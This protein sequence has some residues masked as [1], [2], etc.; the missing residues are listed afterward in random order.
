MEDSDPAPEKP[1]GERGRRAAGPS[2]ARA[3]ARRAARLRKCAVIRVEGVERLVDRPYPR[4]V[5]VAYFD[6]RLTA[7]LPILREAEWSAWSASGAAGRP[8][9][10][11]SPNAV[12]LDPRAAV[13]EL[14]S[15]LSGV[16][17]YAESHM[18]VAKWLRTLFEAAGETLEIP[19]RDVRELA[20]DFASEDR[21][22]RSAAAY[23]E[24][25]YA[26]SG[27]AARQATCM[28]A[29]LR[30]L[31]SEPDVAPPPYPSSAHMRRESDDVR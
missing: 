20:A 31:G 8:T 15:A 6:G 16:K 1:A 12:G 9:S 11:H 18:A 5:A 2:T 23:A 28:V 27:R 29:F 14:R 25:L 30:A 10:L 22:W 26:D 4:E 7:S 21:R 19:V 13:A 3:A 24:S 17:A